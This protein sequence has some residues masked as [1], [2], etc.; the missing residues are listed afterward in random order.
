M[1][2]RKSILLFALAAAF[3]FAASAAQAGCGSCGPAKPASACPA[4]CDKPC[5]AKKDDCAEVCCAQKKT[6]DQAAAT[7]CSAGKKAACQAQCGQAACAPGACHKL[8]GEV[9][10]VDAA[11]RT[12]VVKHEAIEGMME[13]MTMGFMVPECCDISK[14]AAGDHITGMV[15]KCDKG[16]L[17]KCIEVQAAH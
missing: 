2:N 9:V 6:C 3:S 12:V 17:L 16:Y 10:S 8:V 7:A 1:K 5:C 4:G 11:K 15:S 14:L 13:A